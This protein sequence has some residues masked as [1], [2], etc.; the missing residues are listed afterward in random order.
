MLILII[1]LNFLRFIGLET[2]PPGFYADE[3]YGATQVICLSQTGADFFNH[4]LPLFSISGP[5]E[6][7]YTPAY[8]YGQLAWTWL[9]GYSI[10]AFR[11][12]PAFITSL[13]IFF[14]YLYARK[15]LNQKAAIYIAFAA[16]IM[17]WAFQFSR[18]AWDPPLAPFFLILSLW[19][20]TLKAR[21]WIAG[22]PLALSIYSYPPLRIIAPLIWLFL[23]FVSIKRK[24]IVIGIALLVCVPLALQLKSEIFI[25]RS[26]ML[27][28]W[29]STFYN[30]YRH[31]S[32]LELVIVFLKNWVAHFSPSFLFM[33]GE[34]NLRHSVQ[35][36]G[37]LSWLDLMALIG[38][39]YLFILRIFRGSPKP[40]FLHQQSLLVIFSAMGV[41]ISIIPAALTNEA[42]PHALR[43]ISAWPFYAMLTGTILY[44]IEELFPKINLTAIV[45]VIGCTFFLSYQ[46]YFFYKYPLISR[47]GFEAGFSNNILYP[48]LASGEASC[49]DLRQQV[50]KM[51][52]NT[53]I[54]EVIYFSK[55]GTGPITSYLNNHWY[56]REDWGIWSDGMNAD[57]I[58]PVPHGMPKKIIVDL[59]VLITPV[60]PEQILE[61]WLN[62]KLQEKVAI[63]TSEPVQFEI[64]L[65]E[66]FDELKPLNIEFRTPNAISPLEAEIS[67]SDKRKL[68]VGLR[69]IKFL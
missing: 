33:Q 62:G 2:S 66:L 37:M 56:D 11:S 3:S 22:I 54:G 44:R 27:T 28:I 35:A 58:I 60:H 65:P 64:L 42:S 51:D 16:T 59:N 32:L 63:R 39:A 41:L 31:Y 8:L 24:L 52:L 5:G 9:W 19:C 53:R 61:I 21:W 23:P 45:L 20:S 10:S 49:T 69:N 38:M 30:S 7:I 40:I 67:A 15:I 46:Y 50:K 14:L 26:N 68:G 18:I 25:S 12:Y 48:R 4:F 29:S 57:I 13:T 1:L 6:P 17:P 55:N 47:E 34:N 43:T 36:Y